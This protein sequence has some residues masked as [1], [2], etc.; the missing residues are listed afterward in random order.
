MRLRTS[1]G[2][3]RELFSGGGFCALAAGG[4]IELAWGGYF[5]N[6]WPG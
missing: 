1:S 2:L 6:V 3:T 5:S 4:G